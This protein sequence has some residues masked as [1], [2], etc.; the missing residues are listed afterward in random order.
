MV[1]IK[2]INIIAIIKKKFKYLKNIKI[3]KKSDLLADNIL[4]S[5]ELMELISDL[6]KINKFD[7]KKYYK[8]NKYFSVET[9]EKYCK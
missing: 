2:K 8:R 9:L 1:K 4:D 6:E 5:L 3:T 7:I